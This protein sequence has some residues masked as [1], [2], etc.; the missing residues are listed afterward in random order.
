VRLLVTRPEPDGERTA[1]V[2]RTRGHDVL[3]APLLRVEAV[4][5]ADLGQGPWTGV[6]ITSANAA[7]ALASHPRRAELMKLPLFAVGRR[8]AEAASA[9]GFADVTSADGDARDLVRLLVARIPD[10]AGAQSGLRATGAPLLYLAGEDRAV[11]LAAELAA[12]GV[13]VRTVAVYRTVKAAALPPPLRAALAAGQLDGVLHFS[14]RSA[15]AFVACASFAAVLDRALALPHYCLSPQVAEPL[16][17]AGATR[18]AIAPRP[19]EAALLDL[20]RSS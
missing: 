8:S 2:L 16:A 17:A 11:D 1:A 15:E 20:M 7:R 9:A 18:I 13:P 12:H 3:L 10:F 4:A 19:D 5:A 6:V 14:R